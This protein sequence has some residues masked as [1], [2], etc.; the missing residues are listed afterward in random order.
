MQKAKRSLILGRTLASKTLLMNYKSLLICFRIKILF[1]QV[2]MN[3][4][5]LE[6][7]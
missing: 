7:F 2:T 3:P 5:R 6:F 1:E 4:G